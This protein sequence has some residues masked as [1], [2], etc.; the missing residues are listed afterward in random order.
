VKLSEINVGDEVRVRRGYSTRTAIVTG[1]HAGRVGV[2]FTDV[3]RTDPAI[4][5]IPTTHRSNLFGAV[6]RPNTILPAVSS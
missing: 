2:S 5:L 4:H 1:F 6:V 3:D